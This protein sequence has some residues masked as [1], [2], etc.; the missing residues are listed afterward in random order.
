MKSPK[1]P[2]DVILA[3]IITEQAMDEMQNRKYTFRVNP[4]ANKAEISDAVESLFEGTKVE[5][6]NTINMMGKR[7]RQG[8]KI[9]KRPDWKK[10][11]VTLTE[12]SKSIEVFEGMQ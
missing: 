11:V 8:M 6:V 4:K 5:R 2:Y 9:S 10:A 12:D 3:P 7:V 1:T